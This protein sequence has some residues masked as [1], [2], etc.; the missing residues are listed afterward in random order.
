MALTTTLKFGTLGY[1]RQMQSLSM[2]I[3]KMEIASND[4]KEFLETK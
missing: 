1:T 3:K 2:L 4:I